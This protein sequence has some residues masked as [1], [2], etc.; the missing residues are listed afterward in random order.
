MSSKQRQVLTLFAFLNVIVYALLGFLIFVY[1][2]AQSRSRT[3][4]TDIVVESIKLASDAA[5]AQ[6]TEP[7]AIHPNDTAISTV[8]NTPAPWEEGGTWWS[9]PTAADAPV[10]TPNPLTKAKMDTSRSVSQRVVATVTPISQA[11]PLSPQGGDSPS[12]PIPVSD[13][14]RQLGPGASIWYK[15]GKGGDHIDLF[16][17]AS[18][19]SAML[20]QVFAP[21]NLDQPIGQGSLERGRLVWAGG[22]W[23]SSS[24][25]LARVTNAGQATVWYH[26]VS[27]TREIGVCDSISYWEY[28]G[29]QRVYWTR[30]K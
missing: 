22:K 1:I 24:D 30:C 13:A 27:Y 6:P 7:P 23:N 18:D 2:P 25:W 10:T 28:I 9:T 14:W 19:L 16:L 17:D 20:M 12:N 3:R 26:M 11:A 29:K 8:T 15:I 21:G 5:A 4:A